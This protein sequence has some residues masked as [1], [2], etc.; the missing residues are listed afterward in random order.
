MNEAP[1]HAA[2]D[3]SYRARRDEFRWDDVTVLDYKADG[4]A[5]FREVTRQV[6]FES[7]EMASQLRYF[8]VAPGRPQHARTP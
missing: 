8:E 2:T 4:E 5:P 1:R 3:P 6:L 7:A